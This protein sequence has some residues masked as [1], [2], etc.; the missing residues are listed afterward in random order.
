MKL[1]I[2]KAFDTVSRSYLLEVLQALRS[3]LHLC[4]LVSILFRT[5][6]SR[7][8][9]NGVPGGK[10]QHA[11]GVRQGDL[12]L[13]MLFI[14][15]MDPL[16]RLLDLATSYNVLTQLPLV[17]AKWR[18]STYD[19][20]AAIFVNPKKEDIDAIKIILETFRKVSGLC[21]NMD[22]SSIHMIRCKDNKSLV[23][24]LKL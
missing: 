3:G 10:S 17:V 16:Q 12:L 22:K 2:Q 20:D 11:R 5:A 13:L 14:L 23:T 24:H 4:E 8:L 1:D 6:A 18:L 19:D 21:I 9:L 7:A 15:A